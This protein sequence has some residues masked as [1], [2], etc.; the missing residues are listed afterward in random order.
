MSLFLKEKEI[1]E[2]NIILFVSN[3]IKY[4]L[5]VFVKNGLFIPILIGLLFVSIFSREKSLKTILAIIIGVYIL[6]WMSSVIQQ[7]CSHR[8]DINF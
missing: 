3:K 7:G 5:N 8:Y 4:Y 2:T 6:I 1:T